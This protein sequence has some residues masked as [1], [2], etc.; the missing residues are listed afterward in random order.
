M[1]LEQKSFWVD[2]DYE[3]GVVHVTIR[4]PNFHKTREVKSQI[5]EAHRFLGSAFLG[6]LKMSGPKL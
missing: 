1:S 5:S 6:V 4:V 3:V 2:A